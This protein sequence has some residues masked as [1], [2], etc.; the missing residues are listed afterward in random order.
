VRMI[1]PVAPGRGTGQAW[2]REE[3][4]KPEYARARPSLLIRVLTWLL[5]GL[6]RAA[7][8]T[9]LGPGQLVTLVLAVAVV[10]IVVVVL[11]R[12]RVRLSVAQAGPSR[13]VLG[14]STLSGAEHR[15]LAQQATASGRYDEAVREWMRAVA[16]RL[17]ERALVDPRPGRTADELAV[18]T[19][20]LLPQ[21]R[22]DLAAGAR[23][24]DDVVYGSVH[25][26]ALHADQLRRL[27]EQV[28]A[29]KPLVPST[30][31]SIP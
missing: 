31:A 19:G 29:A 24:F 8:R 23:T 22:A 3:L 10:V 1:G 25:A 28:E 5:H 9:G 18:E 20:R 2:A 15:L 27:D 4:A 12:R 17:D 7:A 13:A 6:E 21:L 26:T 14:A 11:T 30:F 16:R